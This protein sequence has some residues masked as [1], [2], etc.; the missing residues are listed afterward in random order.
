MLAW[1]VGLA[2][3]SAIL[4]LSVTYWVGPAVQIHPALLQI[5]SWLTISILWLVGLILAR[6]KVAKFSPSLGQAEPVNWLN[7]LRKRKPTAEN[8]EP[9]KQDCPGQPQPEVTLDLEKAVEAQVSRALTNNQVKLV[10]EIPE[11]TE[12]KIMGQKWIVK[13]GKLTITTQKKP[14]QDITTVFENR[15]RRKMA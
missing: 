4:F 1:I 10:L 2:I 5:V 7:A 14:G 8:A 6:I 9:E 15:T 11:D 3:T 13:K 12:L